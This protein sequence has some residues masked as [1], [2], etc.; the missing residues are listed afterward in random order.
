MFKKIFLLIAI[1]SIISYAGWEKLSSNTSEWLTDVFF[2]NDLYGFSV[3]TNGAIVKT[4][5]GGDSWINISIQSTEWL[6][7]VYFLNK[8]KGFIV[9][10]NG[11][12]VSTVDGGTSWTSQYLPYYV[13]F[14]AIFFTDDM[15][16]WIAGGISDG[17]GVILKTTDGGNNWL[18]VINGYNMEFT[19]IG[20]K[21]DSTRSTGLFV[22]R[23]SVL[24]K[25][26]DSGYSWAQNTISYNVL[27]SVTFAGNDIWVTGD[28]GT[29][30]KSNNDGQ[31]WHI[32]I[33]ISQD[34]LFKAKFLDNNYGIVVGGYGTGYFSESSIIL[35]TKDGGLTW[36][37]TQNQEWQKLY[38]VSVPSK[39]RAYAVGYNGTIVRYNPET[40]DNN[41]VTKVI[42]EKIPANFEL[43]QNY[44][45]PFNPTTAIQFA[46][47]KPSNVRI[48]IY[49]I[50]G[51]LVKELI[52]E[53]KN[54]GIYSIIWNGKDKSG[55][56]LASGTYFYNI[57]A[58][59]FIQTK[60]M[61]LLK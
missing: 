2:V 57:Q 56:S 27:E 45:N 34:H 4:T 60:K 25:S 6:A 22:S 10:S 15:N 8:D 59:S 52:N 17:N 33:P 31:T 29:L 40:G 5:D 47:P 28:H 30:L 21:S 55:S 24:L 43:L 9:G 20:F 42:N 11:I 41:K 61:I 44:P 32:F 54:T 49:D 3:G 26:T 14:H 38:S 18:P 46:I 35:L 53:Q 7:G 50:M 19:G 36:N 51:R 1:S 12:L 37:I 13:N 23:E 16:G 58:G 48:N 39:S